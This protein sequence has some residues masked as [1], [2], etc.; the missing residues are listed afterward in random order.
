MEQINKTY[1]IA[2]IIFGLLTLLTMVSLMIEAKKGREVEEAAKRM[3]QEEKPAE[4]KAAEIKGDLKIVKGGDGR[5]MVLIPAGSFTMGGG[6]EAE[7]DEQPEREILLDAYY[8][9]L[10]EVRNSDYR[11][12]ASMTKRHEQFVPVFE[13]DVKLLLQPDLPAVGV[14]WLDAQAYCQWAGKRL[15]TEAEWEKA[16][17]GTDRRDYPWGD[18]WN[19]KRANAV[20]TE[21]GFR[22]AASVDSY[23]EGRSPYGLYNAAGNAAEWVDS[24]YD[25]FYYKEMPFRNPRG[26]EKGTKLVYRG[27]SWHDSP[28]NL[29]ASKRFAGSHPERTDSNIGFRCARDVE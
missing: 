11:R 26:P 10:Y 15:P 25:T 19:P 23:P 12:F 9:D 27:G 6:P 5:E 20:G 3:V 7:I 28:R 13:D 1:I 16:A 8:I 21:D 29:R 24:W 22:Y 4:I 18:D 17:R 14:S 2:T